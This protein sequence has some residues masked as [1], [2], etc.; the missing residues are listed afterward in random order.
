M[1]IEYIRYDLGAHQAGDLVRVSDA[2]VGAG[3]EHR[4]G[5]R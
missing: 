4:I 5:H 2:A 3:V 1:T